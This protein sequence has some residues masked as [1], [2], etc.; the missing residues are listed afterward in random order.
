MNYEKIVRKI[1]QR[2]FDYD[3]TAKE[4]KAG[5]VLE[6]AKKRMLKNLVFGD[7]KKGRYSGLTRKELNRTGTCETD[8]Y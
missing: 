8:W 5:R 3:G 2:I 4:D 1:R 6:K 7:C